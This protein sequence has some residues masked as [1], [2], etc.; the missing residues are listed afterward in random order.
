MA[1]S[2]IYVGDSAFADTYALESIALSDSVLYIEG[3]AF[4]VSGLIDIT[5]PDSVEI[6]GDCAFWESIWLESITL[7]K[8]LRVIK[9]EAFLE[10]GYLTSIIIPKV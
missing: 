3:Y 5:L 4:W 6:I 8:N 9:E 7:S 1:N 10:C 2:V